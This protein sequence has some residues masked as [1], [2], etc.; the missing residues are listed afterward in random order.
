MGVVF[1]LA[2]V[3]VF[4]IPWCRNG[5]EVEDKNE[6]YLLESGD[7]AITDREFSE[8]LELKRAAYPYD[9]QKNPY[10]Y[11]VLV[12]QLV[13]QLAEELVLRRAARDRGVFVTPEEV[14]AEEDD[15]RQDY[16][17]NSF[18]KM[19]LENAISHDFWRYRLK[20]NLLFERLIDKD[21]RQRVEISPLEMTA[22][23]NEIKNNSE[24]M[25]DGA[26]LVKTI[27]MAK[28][29]A[30]YPAW[31][32]GLEEEYPV[33]INRVNI[34]R[35]LKSVKENEGGLTVDNEND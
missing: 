9:I 17:E 19:L 34:D 11:N 1:S 31:I 26:E 7:L 5:G 3:F 8:G 29:E 6:V 32:K 21:L 22:G 12:I 25:P 33:L 35:Y 18:E 27:R 2:A 14:E 24:E 10:E 4:L 15:I 16:P 13:D 30:E 20:L 23:Y 28:A